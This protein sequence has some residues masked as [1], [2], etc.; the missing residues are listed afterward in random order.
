MAYEDGNRVDQADENTTSQPGERGQRIKN[1]RI[2][3]LNNRTVT[4]PASP[5]A[6]FRLTKDIH[7]STCYRCHREPLPELAESGNE[8]HEFNVFSGLSI[9][10]S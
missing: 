9:R 1:Y 7:N 4:T 8:V 6:E 5:S 2:V 3:L 10:A